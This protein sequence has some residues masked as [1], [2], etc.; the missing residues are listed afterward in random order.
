MQEEG[1]TIQTRTIHLPDVHQTALATQTQ[2]CR[3]LFSILKKSSDFKLRLGSNYVYLI[4]R[5][6]Y[7]N[8]DASPPR[9]RTF[10]EAPRKFSEEPRSSKKKAKKKKKKKRVN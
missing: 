5:E 1:G 4:I 6:T 9:K 3:T 2:V 7:F 8:S 10:T